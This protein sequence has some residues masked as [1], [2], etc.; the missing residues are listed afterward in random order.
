MA[1]SIW[2]TSMRPSAAAFVL[3]DLFSA[4]A[5]LGDSASASASAA[6]KGGRISLVPFAAARRIPS[7]SR[8]G[9][10]PIS[11]GPAYFADALRTVTA[12]REPQPVDRARDRG[13]DGLSPARGA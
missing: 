1:A 13:G 5:V 8:P 11:Q 3:A 6:A 2:A 10:T 7:N 12:W 9:T 4:P